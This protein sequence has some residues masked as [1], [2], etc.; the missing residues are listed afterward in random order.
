V[1]MMIVF[2][3]PANNQMTSTFDAYA[4]LIGWV[5][6]WLVSRRPA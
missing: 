1:F 5:G 3:F 2:Y 4:T 6:G